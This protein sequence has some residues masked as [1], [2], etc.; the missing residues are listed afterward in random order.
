MRGPVSP[1]H[2][3]AGGLDPPSNRWTCDPPH[4]PAHRIAPVSARRGR[5]FVHRTTKGQCVSQQRQIS[6]G[7]QVQVFHAFRNRPT[8]RIRASVPQGFRNRCHYAMKSSL[9]CLELSGDFQELRMQ[10]RLLH[11]ELLPPFPQEPCGLHH[12]RK[13]GREIGSCIGRC[14][15][16]HSLARSW[17][18]D[19]N[20]MISESCR[21]NSFADCGRS[22]GCLAKHARTS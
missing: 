1:G 4:Q 18:Q 10:T 11:C 20:P 22:F 15:A 19:G 12:C 6:L 7:G 9:C 2:K 17:L 13:L 16:H 14:L 21:D 3:R 5:S 8:I